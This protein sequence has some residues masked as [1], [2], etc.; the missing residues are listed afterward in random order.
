M[1]EKV[2]DVVKRATVSVTFGG[3]VISPVVPLLIWEDVDVKV[4]VP[5]IVG[6]FKVVELIVDVLIVLFDIVWKANKYVNV[7][8]ALTF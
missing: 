4:I 2:W 3:I 7:S 5:E 1:F 6:E 8:E